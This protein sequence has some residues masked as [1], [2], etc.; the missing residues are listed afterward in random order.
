MAADAV[1]LN[2]RL[3]RRN[4]IRGGGLR[5]GRSARLNTQRERCD[6]TDRSGEH[7]SPFH[8]TGSSGGNASSGMTFAHS[9]GHGISFAP[10]LR[11]STAVCGFAANEFP[12]STPSA[13]TRGVRPL[14][15]CTSSFAP[16]SNRY[17]TTLLAPRYA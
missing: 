12:Y 3:V 8:R 10:S 16:L 11:S 2:D 1:F 5:V 9:P 13:T 14:L 15:S 17:C 4:S 6:E 7:G